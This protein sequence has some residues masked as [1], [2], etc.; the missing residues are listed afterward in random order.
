MLS[1]H[2]IWALIIPATLV[3][4]K[5]LPPTSSLFKFQYP[6]FSSVPHWLS[7]RYQTDFK[8][9]LYIK[10]DFMNW[11]ANC[12]P[13]VRTSQLLPELLHYK[14]EIFCCCWSL[15]Q[16]DH[17]FRYILLNIQTDIYV[18]SKY[19]NYGGYMSGVNCVNDKYTL[20]YF[21]AINQ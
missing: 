14:K 12:V 4:A 9:S 19:K 5:S 15:Y 10:S 21:Y 20:F 6:E 2:Q 17:S 3:W 13:Q 8:L 7:I 1:S 11:A 16:K 18:K